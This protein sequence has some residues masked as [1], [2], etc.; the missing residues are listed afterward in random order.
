MTTAELKGEIKKIVRQML[1]DAQ[2]F[3][4]GSRV[5]E[6]NRPNSDID[7][8]IK[9]EKKLT[10]LQLA[11]VNDALMESGIPY[12]A[13]IHDYHGLSADFLAA[14]ADDLTE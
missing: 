6:S 9:S 14:I 3:F 7:I 13:D 10:L 11:R 4:F 8:L 5:K 1:P 2:V 12:V